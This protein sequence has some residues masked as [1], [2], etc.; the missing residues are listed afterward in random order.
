MKTYIDDFQKNM[1]IKNFSTSTQK[2]YSY[3]LKYYLDYCENNNSQINSESFKNYIYSLKVKDKLSTST[4]KQ[5]VGAVKFFTGGNAVC[6]RAG[7]TR[8]KKAGSGPGYQKDIFVKQ[9]H[10]AAEIHR[11]E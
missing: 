10:R 11:Q 4:L 9:P 6:L 1:V 7:K 3:M 5:N 8:F 2:S